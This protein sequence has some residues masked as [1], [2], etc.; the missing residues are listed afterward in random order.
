V[1]QFGHLASQCRFPWLLANVLDPALGADVPLG[2][3][4]KTHMLTASNGL[5]IGLLGLGEREWLE[6]VNALPPGVVCRPAAEVARE[7]VPQLRAHGADLVVALT[8]M[9]EPGDLALAEQLA[10]TDAA[11]DL[12]LGGHDH[13]YSHS[14]VRGRTHVLRSG[15][16]FKQLSYLELRRAAAD[17]GSGRRWDV[18][19]WRRDVVRAVREDA[20][21]LALVDRLTAKLKKSLEKP[22]GFTAA[23]LDARFTT[24]RLRESNLGNFVCDLMRHHYGAECALMAAGTIRGDQVY[25]PGPIRVRDVTDCFPFEDPIVVIKVSGRAIW[26]ALEN[27][28]SLYP[29]LEGSHAPALL[30]LI[31]LSS[32]GGLCTDVTMLTRSQAGSPR[33]P[34]SDSPSTPR[35]PPARASSRPRSAARRWIPAGSTSSPRGGTWAAARTATAACWCGPRAASARNWCQ[36]RMASSSRPCCASTSCP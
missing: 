5:R 9:R 29:A 19:I 17:D 24:V 18:D 36:R 30:P 13:F 22:V 12:I 27:G 7:L 26:D 14:L 1:L 21:T 16:D 2:G 4:A 20:E 25:P 10:G 33:C 6:T 3:A 11:P 15:S 23:P 28:V 31:P 35:G 8:H 32:Y 34:T